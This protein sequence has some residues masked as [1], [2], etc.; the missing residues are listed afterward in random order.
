MFNFCQTTLVKKDV[1]VA[2]GA[3]ISKKKPVRVEF[4]YGFE[5][6][7]LNDKLHKILST[8]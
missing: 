8:T 5:L 7:L 2:R 1:P 4:L 6:Q 3:V